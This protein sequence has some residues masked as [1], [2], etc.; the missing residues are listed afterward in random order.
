MSLQAINDGQLVQI[1]KQKFP[2]ASEARTN[3][4]L[5]DLAAQINK[6]ASITKGTY[7]NPT[8]YL[9]NR[10]YHHSVDIIGRNSFLYRPKL[11]VG[12]NVT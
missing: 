5:S 10:K 1:I 8:T 2:S 11:S 7:D 3:G 6:V 4:V 12:S 9:Q